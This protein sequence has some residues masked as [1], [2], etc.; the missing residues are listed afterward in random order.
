MTNAELQALLD[1]EDEKVI[2]WL[3]DYRDG[4]RRA[5]DRIILAKLIELLERRAERNGPPRS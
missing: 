5:H 1:R 2:P 4:S 3:R